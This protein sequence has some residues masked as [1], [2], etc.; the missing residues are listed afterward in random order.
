[1][2]ANAAREEAE[3]GVKN[4]GCSWRGGLTEKG[5]RGRLGGACGRSGRWGGVIIGAALLAAVSGCLAASR[6][7][8]ATTSNRAAADG[9][10]RN[11]GT[12]RGWIGD[13]DQGILL[14]E[15]PCDGADF[16]LTGVSQSRSRHDPRRADVPTE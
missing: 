9:S 16:G 4:N 11:P 2:T 15:V 14:D 1:M 13:P 3:Q 8:R 12:C 6:P 10:P 7:A 5:G